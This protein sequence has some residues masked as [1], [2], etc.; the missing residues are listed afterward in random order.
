MIRTLHFSDFLKLGRLHEAEVG[1]NLPDS[2][3]V[4]NSPL[5]AAIIQRLPVH[6]HTSSVLIYEE[7]RKPEAFVQAGPRRRPEEWNV[8]ALGV[9]D[10][11][12]Q[13]KNNEENLRDASGESNLTEAPSSSKENETGEV[14]VDSPVNSI[15]PDSTSGLPSPR[16]PE[17]P[18][19]DFENPRGFEKISAPEK[20]ERAHPADETEFAWLKLL[21]QLVVEAGEKGVARIYAKLTTES[22]QMSL[23]SQTGFHSFTHESLFTL[24]YGTQLEP[25]S[26]KLRSQR[27][28]DSWFIDQLYN[29]I[30]PSFVKNSEQ[31][32]SRDWEI[33][34]GYLPRP[35]RE[36]GWVLDE[37]EKI[38]AYVR[39][40]SNR[41][42]HVIRILN[43]DS[44]RHLLP[45]ILNFALSNIKAG[46]DCFVYCTVREYQA[47]QESI[48]E[49]NGFIFLGKQAVM[50]KHTVQYVRSAEKILS[51]ARD[52][53][54]ELA[55]SARPTLL[56]K[57]FARLPFHFPLKSNF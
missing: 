21:E 33:H 30:T 26:L 19:L 54:L 55:H 41:K 27:N 31:T 40:I 13:S 50:V 38:V 24:R 46:P 1:L 52:R 39:L 34:K 35:A 5:P 53:K 37:G 45:E 17:D 16:V 11:F 44:H 12:G 3:V 25:S 36:R 51:Q 56:L 10:N 18:S 2:L 7:D 14:E 48:L 6:S 20:F 32:S 49:D 9:V 57:F 28:R 4:P 47:E 43:L 23:F 42:K 22:Q 15:L 8:L 29:S